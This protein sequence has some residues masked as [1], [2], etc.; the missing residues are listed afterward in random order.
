MDAQKRLT[1]ALET[2]MLFSGNNAE[3]R[4]IPFITTFPQSCNSDH[5]LSG[6]FGRC[7][8]AALPA[9]DAFPLPGQPRPASA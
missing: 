3:R 6:R 1:A 8:E 4:N 2:G 5:A 9:E 7:A